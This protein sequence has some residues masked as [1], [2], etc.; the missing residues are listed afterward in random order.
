[1]QHDKQLTISSAGSRKA[2]HWPAQT[3]YWSE[4]IQKLSTPI[5]G[6]ET[7]AEYIQLPKRQQDDLK[8]VGGFV[9]GLLRGNRRKPSNVIGRDILTLDMDNIP[10]GGTKDVLRRVDALGCAYAVYSTRK[11][12]EARP[13]LRILLPLSRTATADEYEPLTRKLAGIIGIDMCDPTTFQVARLMYWPSCC[14]DSQYIYQYADKP[15]LDTDGLLSLYNDWHDISEWPEV[16]GVQQAYSNHAARQGDPTAKNGAIGAFCKIY[17]IYRAIE[18]FIPGTYAPCE[19]MPDRFTYTGGSTVGGAI[20]YDNGTFLYSH[21]ATDPA[22]GRLCN[23]FDLVRLHRFAELDDE[24]KPD[25]PVNKL[26]S[27]TAMCELAV[28]DAS[29]ASLL[30]QERYDKATQDFNNDPDAD[31]NWMQKLSVSPTTGA[32]AKT[33]DNVLIIMN[34]DPLLRD[35]IA[36]DEF[37]NRGLVLGA[38]P[39]DKRYE[40]RQWT[41]VDDAG[42]R[43][44]LEKVYAITGKER[45]YDAVSLCAHQNMINDVVDYLNTLKWDG[46]KRIDTL[47]IDYL[48]A[49]DSVYTR[50]VTRK[51][52]TAAVARAM[53]PGTKYDCMPIFAGPQGIGKST[54]LRILG[55][56]W[57]SDSL[58]T[59]EGKEASEMIQGVWIN[60]VGELNG[61]SRSETNAVKQFLSKTEDIFREP[62]G[63]RTGRYP[64]RC[65]FFGTTNDT[66]F[67]R[68]RTGNRRFWPVDV[69]IYQP[70]KDIF[71]Q[72]ED[73]VDQIWAE[74]M[75]YWRLGEA[76]YLSG[77][78][79][80]EANRQQ[81]EHQEVDSKEGLIIDFLERK[82]PPDWDK[83]SKEARRL[84][85]SNEFD[86]YDGELFERERVCALEIWYECFGNDIK[87]MRKSDARE[88]NSIMNG[89]YGWTK[90]PKA[91]RYGWCG[92]QRGG[93]F[94]TE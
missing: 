94:K 62:Y 6:V 60:E 18:E 4:L 49:T 63:K 29:V 79:E 50:A 88:I 51:S 70:T 44:Y 74:A 32:P 20:I 9:A 8:D 53:R 58:Q 83:R 10:A 61:L 75:M 72:L 46:I 84:F 85:W 14:S 28:S 5:R 1:M 48:G 15:F 26:P 89:L 77:E 87:Y 64:R 24:S 3:I 52:L 82:I 35:K 47:L 76:L 7:L 78:T 91:A 31:I 21:H 33:R 13:R 56:C 92:V 19:S 67:L 25:T 34:Y 22:G 86:N 55:K 69:G 41:D 17:D 57:Y 59:F 54:F 81:Q 39:W 93:F 11:H 90:H 16:P 38:L 27:F 68:D 42:L 2:V 12:E 36:F 73:E 45:I 37:A 30:N 66:E 40:R 80:E 43:H 71:N 65:V 23:A